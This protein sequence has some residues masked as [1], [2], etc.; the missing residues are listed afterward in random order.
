MRRPMNG[1]SK[2]RMDQTPT[3]WNGY[4]RYGRRNMPLPRSLAHQKRLI[5]EA[6]W[7]EARAW[8]TDKI[9]RRGYK[10]RS[11][12]QSPQEPTSD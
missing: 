8:A 9:K 10:P 1:Q 4:D 2:R 3:E 5:S 12:T 6:K 7:T 11:R